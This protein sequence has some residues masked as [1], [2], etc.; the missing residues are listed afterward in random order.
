MNIYVWIPLFCDAERTRSADTDLIPV[1]TLLNCSFS[2]SNVVLFLF[3]V[4]EISDVSAIEDAPTEDALEYVPKDVTERPMDSEFACRFLKRDGMSFLLLIRAILDGDV[5]GRWLTRI[6]K[7][8][9]EL[10][11]IDKNWQELKRIDEN[12]RELIWID[13]NWQELTIIDKDR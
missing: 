5:A 4:G 11:R 13:K 8:W 6:D 3:L 12:W 10:T 1:I 7:N 2:L 9:Q